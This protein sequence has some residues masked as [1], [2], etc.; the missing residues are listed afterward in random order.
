MAENKRV[1]IVG[2]GL[3]GLTCACELLERGCSVTV[4][5][6]QPNLGGNSS[7]A[8]CGIAAPGS[9]L[10]QKAGIE[11]AAKDLVAVE[12]QLAATI[13]KAGSKDVDWL[14][15]RLGVED[16]LV[17]HKTPGHAEARTLGSTKFFPGMV[18][19]Y[20]A[21]QILQRIADAKPEMI[22]IVPSAE[23]TK[24]LGS[25]GKVTGV[26]YRLNGETKTI[27]GP[28]VLATGGYAGDLSKNSIIA[29][30][31]PDLLSYPTS[32]DGR[33]NGAGVRLAEA[34]GAGTRR[35][36]AVQLFPNTLE[37]PGG[38]SSLK[39]IASDALCG[40]GA[41]LLDSKGNRFCDEMGT[42]DMRVAAMNK[43]LQQGPVYFVMPQEKAASVEWLCHFYASKNVMRTTT[44]AG[45]AADVGRPVNDMKRLLGDGAIYV[46]E[47]TPALYSCVGGLSV[48]SLPN[49]PKASRVLMT[50]G[51]PIEGLYAAG[52]V[53]DAPF[54][55]LMAVSGI[56][57]L[58]CIYS[59]RLAGSVVAKS[60]GKTESKDLKQITIDA[61]TKTAAP[62]EETAKGEDEKPLED[63]SKEDLI[64]VLKELQS[65]PAAVAPA[66][67]GGGGITMEEVA[68]HNKKDDAWIVLNGEVIDVTKWIP[69]HPG[70]E[71]AICAYLGQD[72]TDEWNMIHKPGMVEKNAQHLGMKGKLGAGGGGGGGGGGGAVAVEAGFADLEEV[73]K[74]NK[75]EDAWVAIN[76]QV[77]NVTNFIAVHPGGVQAIMAYVG[78]DASDEWNT[79]HKP[80]TV[81]R[82]AKTQ[83]GPIIL[84]DLK[85]GGGPKP[86]PGP[87]DDSKP[88]PEGDG[89]IP[90]TLG[91]TI[92]LAKAVIVN[93]AM[94]IMFTGNFVFKF[95]N[96][97][98][99]TI[100]SAIFLLFFTIVHVGGNAWDF[101]QG[102]DE[103][104]G[105]TYFFERQHA[106]MGFVGLA[107]LDAGP[108]EVYLLLAGLLHVS[109][110]LKR[111][112]DISMGYCLHTG[113]WN[114]LL[115]GLV[116]LSF[117]CKHLADFRFFDGY[118]HTYIRPAPY[119]VNP[120]GAID[121]HLWTDPSA[122][123]MLVRD[124]Y[125]REWEVFSHTPTVV[126]YLACVFVFVCHMCWGWAKVI[127][128]D[129]LQI[130]RGHVEK[131]KWMGW[132][133]A[134]S[135]GAL[136]S[137]VALGM[138]FSE[139]AVIKQVD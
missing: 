137:T 52:E 133:L 83:N 85:G 117:M 43:A 46:A 62:E 30:K 98:M 27:S 108:L 107:W 132:I 45:L 19:T 96:N 29:Q 64:K 86:P 54:Q 102:P 15:S 2:G 20:A 28:V 44:A 75:Q 17:L 115:S 78:T 82:M 129:A 87:V 70:G 126:F 123:E 124:A 58:H 1:V 118:K 67:G 47:V 105:E 8:T 59:G 94:T 103:M 130:P 37:A 16:Q 22:Q 121:G 7:K 79:I 113:K 39:I 23:V 81:E 139:K 68:K 127:T 72:A 41:V 36:D 9:S 49:D 24:L 101:F 106:W 51:K 97:R 76:G 21:I 90:G 95:E 38:A 92:F 53:T 89:G 26:E 99:G 114:M 10:Q 5:D 61:L 88:P 33:S 136:Y 42:S 31:R 60:M 57:L 77:I 74:H 12:G 73:A 65:R 25:R 131:V 104:N 111:S 93:I 14:M 63:L 138:H 40:A 66:G 69:I 112:W 119:L 50:D 48:S 71:Q 56:P 110:A 125:S 109:V 32:N 128:A 134:C 80:G 6:K 100:R 4:L 116:I 35:L 13:L 11:D 84:G 3:A 55:K 122:P 91:A 34:V 135:I 120:L 18:V